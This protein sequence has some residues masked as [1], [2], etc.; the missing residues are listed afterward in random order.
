MRNK[1]G[2]LNQIIND[3]IQNAVENKNL[4]LGTFFNN[5][6][7][8]FTRLGYRDSIRGGVE[9]ILILRLDHVG[10]FVHTTGAVREIRNNFPSAYITLVVSKQIYKLA[11]LCPYVNELIPFELTFQEDDP[12]FPHNILEVIS[13][14]TKFASKYLLNRRYDMAFCLQYFNW[15]SLLTPLM[16][17]MSGAQKRYGFNYEVLVHRKDDINFKF[18]TD[19][20]YS[21]KK[22]IHDVDRIFYML[23]SCG[24]KINNQNLE[25][26]CLQQDIKK[27][28]KILA[29]FAPNKIKIALG[30]GASDPKRRYPLERYFFALKKIVDKGSAL[31]IFG[32]SNE[33]YG[34]KLLEEFLPEGSVKN[35]VN[36]NIGWRVEYSLISQLDMYIGNF[37]GLADF[38]DV[39]RVPCIMICPD[40]VPSTS[41]INWHEDFKPYQSKSIIIRPKKGT[42]IDKADPSDIIDAYDTMLEMIHKNI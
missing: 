1:F 3:T 7:N 14:V 22:G 24:L 29:G 5:I 32:G 18:F 17:Y 12:S 41:V 6:E 36:S 15:G 19:V 28:E 2:T 40:Y 25:M 10:D 31:V 38:A 9:S 30:I 26:W 42:A 27:A 4:D 21:P 34:A 8:E 11:E 37:T 35:L 39:C 13:S 16:T 20:I 23:K 33:V